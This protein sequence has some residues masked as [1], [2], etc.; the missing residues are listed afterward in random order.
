MFN[1]SSFYD[2][3][4]GRKQGIGAGIARACLR[5]AAIPYSAVVGLRNFRYDQHWAEIVRVGVPV[6]SVGNL[7][8]GGTGKTPF[9]KWMA[10]HCRQRDLRVAILSRGYGA[11]EG[12]KNDEAME[13]EQA[14]PGVP[15]LQS[16]DRVAI[17]RRA[18]EQYRSQVL[19][20]DDGFQHRRLARDLDIV[21]L[22]A[23]QP[24]GFGYLFPRGTLREPATSLARADVVCL[25]R[26]NQVSA[27]ERT[28]IRGEVQRLAPQAVWCEAI[29]AP[30]Q[31]IN[32]EAETLPIEQLG[33]AKVMAFCGIGN[34]AAFR[35]TLEAAGAQVAEWREFPDHHRYTVEEIAEM[36]RAAQGAGLE[37]I[38]CTHK[39]LVK[40]DHRA[41][42]GVPLWA[43]TVELELLVG[44]TEV[45]SALDTLLATTPAP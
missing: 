43:V 13:L 29:H 24:F 5:L 27:N 16:K 22:D 21:L 15:H 35:G 38:V 10:K 42:A 7:T 26:A 9:V 18:R 37:R 30:S 1:A 25:S 11:A 44:E 40:I 20:L 32:S 28:R 39:D 31:L 12:E 2:L 41:V 6:I 36:G 34:P 23:T 8:L 33:E 17:A 45:A 19:V 4:S 3:V 14:L